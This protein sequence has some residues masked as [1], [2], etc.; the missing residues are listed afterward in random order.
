M[1]VD[2]QRVVYLARCFRR[3]AQG[4]FTDRQVVVCISPSGVGSHVLGQSLPGLVNQGFQRGAD[5]GLLG[6]RGARGHADR[7][8]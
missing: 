7:R 3:V 1:A 2:Q 4:V 5:R 8:A 6:L